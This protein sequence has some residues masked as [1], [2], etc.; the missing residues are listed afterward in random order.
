MNDYYFR[1][2]MFV[3]LETTTIM[4][5][6]KQYSFIKIQFFSIIASLILSNN[7]VLM[8]QLF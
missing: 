6:M 2:D 7:V 3:M 4:D 8:S 1:F 5:I